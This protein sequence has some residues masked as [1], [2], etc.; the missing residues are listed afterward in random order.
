V[1]FDRS[2]QPPKR[3]FF[4]FGPRGVGKSTWLKH[5]FG[6][7]PYVDLLDSETFLR[8]AKSPRELADIVGAKARRGGWV[9]IDEV[10]KVPAV[11]DEV[12]RL[13]EDRGYRFAL[14]GSSARKLRR[15]GANLL[16]GRAITLSMGQLSLAELTPTQ[17]VGSLIDFGGLPLVVSGAVDAPDLLSS[18]V[19]TYLREE[20][21]EEGLVR[22][23]EPFARFLEVA[24]TLNGQVMN[25]ENVAREARVPRSSVEVYFSILE[26]TLLGTRLASYQPGAKVRESTHPKFYWFD[27]GVA[28]AAAGLIRDPVDSVWRGFAFET[29]ILH[30]LRVFN[31][32]AGKHRPLAYY[33]T[34]ADVEIDFIVET[35]KKTMSQKAEVVCIET[36]L[37]RKWD[38]RWER[39]S[40][41]LANTGRVRVRNMIGVYGGE[42]RLSLDG[43]EVYSLRDFVAALYAGEIF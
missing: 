25:L 16:G 11:L 38:R 31:Q 22:K 21:R 34:G 36:K 4:L 30:E 37:A 19:H 7:S 14:T 29:W 26:D 6:D 28:R 3:S 27:P 12:H 33:R 20:I 18:Y 9:C 40:R 2:L 35:K 1:A 41:D 15:G 24:G 13:I 17:Q 5:H 43:F 10:Q 23:V 39:P 42:E 8:L 32:V